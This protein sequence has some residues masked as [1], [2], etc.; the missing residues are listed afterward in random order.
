LGLTEYSEGGWVD[1]RDGRDGQRALGQIR[2]GTETVRGGGIAGA[3]KPLLQSGGRLTRGSQL[4][5]RIPPPG[6]RQSRRPGRGHTRVPVGWL[7]ALVA[8][9]PLG[10]NRLPLQGHP[11]SRPRDPPRR[12]RHRPVSPPPR[13]Q[14][15]HP[16]PACLVMGTL[17]PGRGTVPI[18]H[19][20]RFTFQAGATVR[21]TVREKATRHAKRLDS[22]DQKAVTSVLRPRLYWIQD[23]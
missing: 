13:P 7:P 12:R 22:M 23:I 9:A 14:V 17:E 15:S 11:P 5:E 6:P 1:G 2:D 16:A 10:R 21:D 4:H 3:P 8:T 19:R 20:P 18:R